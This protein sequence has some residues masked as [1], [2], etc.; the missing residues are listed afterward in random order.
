MAATVAAFATNPACSLASSNGDPA[1]LL[2]QADCAVTA[3]K[4]QATPR[5]L[6]DSLFMQFIKTPTT[7]EAMLSFE[8]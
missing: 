7:C 4:P 3:R 2:P 6:L 5:N 8:G 1:A